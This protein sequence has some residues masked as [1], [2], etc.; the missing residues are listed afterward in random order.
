MNYNTSHA[1]QLLRLATA[2]PN[3]SFRESQEE[4]VRHVVEGLT[5]DNDCWCVAAASAWCRGSFSTCARVNK[6]RLN[7]L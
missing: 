6:S 5:L 2:I 3:A 4:A 1:L 7:S